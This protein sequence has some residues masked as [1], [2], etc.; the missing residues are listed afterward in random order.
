[1]FSLKVYETGGERLVAVCDKELL[2]TTHSEGELTLDVKES[3]YGGGEASGE[4]V[5][6]CLRSASIANLV[7]SDV[8]ALAVNDGLLSEGNLLNISG[9]PH[10]QFAV[11]A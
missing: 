8:V 7:G 9:V 1:M 4:E 10:A 11:K 2:G 3:F 5:I 6:E